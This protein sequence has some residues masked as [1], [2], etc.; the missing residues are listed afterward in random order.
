M[1]LNYLVCSR[2]PIERARS[3]SP[4]PKFPKLLQPLSSVRCWPV[5]E[6]GVRRAQ[7]PMI[8][9]IDVGGSVLLGCCVAQPNH[10]S[11]RLIADQS[12]DSKQVCVT[13]CDCLCACVQVCV[14]EPAKEMDKVDIIM[15]EYTEGVH[16]GRSMGAPYLN[17]QLASAV[18]SYVLQTYD[19]LLHLDLIPS[20]GTQEEPGL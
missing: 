13:V 8:N 5:L 15:E 6:G 1:R 20:H 3:V 18:P 11:S 17:S 10:A 4:V 7:I 9:L 14:P 12:T 19:E 16:C 2:S